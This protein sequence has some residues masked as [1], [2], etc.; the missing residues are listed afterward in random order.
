MGWL[1]RLFGQKS[2]QESDSRQELASSIAQ[3]SSSL[4]NA[5]LTMLSKMEEMLE[6]PLSA[7]ERQS[8][9]ES[10]SSLESTL[11]MGVVPASQIKDARER[12]RK[13]RQNLSQ[14]KVSPAAGKKEGGGGLLEKC[15]G[16]GSNETS[17]LEVVRD[18]NNNRGYLCSSCKREYAALLKPDSIRRFWMCGACSFRILAGTKVDAA[19]DPH[20]KC[21]QCGADVNSSLVNL[22]NDQPVKSGM[23]G[24]PSE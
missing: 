9:E 13:L 15:G 20:S 5:T 23:F 14:A 19:V 18:K 4:G 6:K 10:L 11:S 22:S 17:D 2:A 16:C 3:A 12:I 1:S 7:D 8:A 24:E 21:P